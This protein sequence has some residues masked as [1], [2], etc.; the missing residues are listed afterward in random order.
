[1][2]RVAFSN[3]GKATLCF[4][5]PKINSRVYHEMLEHVL[6]SFMEEKMDDDCIFKQNNAYIYVSNM[7]LAWFDQ[8]NISQL[9]WIAC[10]RDLYLMKNLW[11]I[12]A[13][14]FYSNKPQNQ[15]FRRV[16]ELKF[17]CKKAWTEFAL[18]VLHALIGSMPNRTFKVIQKNVEATHY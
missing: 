13:W 14:K 16:T 17:K 7:F 6:I 3:I 4:V 1:M 11:S 2:V 10:N 8:H 5:P 18:E 12:I 9:K 15:T